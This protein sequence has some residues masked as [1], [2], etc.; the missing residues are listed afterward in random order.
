ME[1]VAK[2][3]AKVVRFVGKWCNACFIGKMV[4]AIWD[5]TLDKSP[6]CTPY[7]VGTIPRVPAFSLRL[8]DE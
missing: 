7:I 5:G 3:E 6:L 1:S 8:L 2:G 4:G